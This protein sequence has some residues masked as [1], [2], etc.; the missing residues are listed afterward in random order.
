MSSNLKGT[1]HYQ[2]YVVNNI[3][4]LHS[5]LKHVK[6]VFFSYK[7]KRS[8]YEVEIVAIWQHFLISGKHRY[9]RF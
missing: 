1:L 8:K 6:N 3:K 7:N 2:S 5:V 9:T 4:N